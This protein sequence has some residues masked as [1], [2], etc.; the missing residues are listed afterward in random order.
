M[1]ISAWF[2]KRIAE[3]E[4]SSDPKDI[5]LMLELLS[6]RSRLKL[7]D[8]QVDQMTYETLTDEELLK[9]LRGENV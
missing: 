4:H 8:K 3:L 1:N 7:E 6:T 9:I 5:R 2:D